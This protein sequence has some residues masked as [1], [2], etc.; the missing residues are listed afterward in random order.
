MAAIHS[1]CGGRI[2][3]YIAASRRSDRSL[4][5]RLESARRA[6]EI[7]KR[8]TGRSLRI[9]EQDVLNEELYE[10]E[11]DDQDRRPPAYFEIGSTVFTRPFPAG[12]VAM[13]SALDQT[14][15]SYAQRYPGIPTS[16]YN[17]PAVYP[18][19][20]EAPRFIFIIPKLHPK[21]AA[22][23]SL[24]EDLLVLRRFSA[25]QSRLLLAKQDEIQKVEK[26]LDEIGI[27]DNPSNKRALLEDLVLD[28]G[29]SEEF[30]L[31]LI[32]MRSP[33]I[34]CVGLG[35]LSIDVKILWSD[36]LS[37]LSLSSIFTKIMQASSFE[38]EILTFL[39]R[40]IATLCTDAHDE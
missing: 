27:R 29:K 6:S 18:S 5:A 32:F 19:P 34:A 8:R 2:S 14:I 38:V 24:G 26:C 12:H 17:Q 7:H 20:Y 4:E 28:Y 9:T 21:L 13:R 35:D 39:S 15:Q 31:C 40:R 25:V 23:L 11:V 10:E 33:C 3:A 37:H 22:S 30:L 1:S 16:A 36:K